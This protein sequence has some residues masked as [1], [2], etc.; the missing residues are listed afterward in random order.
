MATDRMQRQI[1]RVTGTR[2]PQGGAML[3]GMDAVTPKG[4]APGWARVSAAAAILALAGCAQPGVPGG[5][6][7][8]PASSAAMPQMPVIRWP[9]GGANAPAAGG[10]SGAVTGTPQVT[11]PFAGQ[12]VAQPEIPP[13]GKVKKTAAPATDSGAGTSAPPARS[14]GTTSSAQT[15]TVVAGETGWSVARKY[16]VSI[17]DLARAN[18]LPETMAIRVGQKLTIPAG[19]SVTAPSVTAPG[20]GSPTPEP[21]SASKPL[22]DEKTQPAS[23]P[24]PKA[25]APDLGKTRTTASGSGKLAMPVSGSIVRAYKKGTNEGIDISAP[26]GSAVSA[27]ASGTVAAVTRD[28]DGVPIVVVRHDD[29]LMTVYAGIDKLSVAKGDS[30]KRGQGIGAA[31]NDGV[32]HFEVRKGFDSVDP[33]DYL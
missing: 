6:G 1:R 12:G 23:K 8:G 31:R 9:L 20:V 5:A 2:L 32:V 17:Q 21:P 3:D 16:G 28:T 22:P 25:D 33:E 15:H 11:D 10:A 27:A 18:G 19:A 14:G 7:A 30:V 13:T 4:A 24:A 29:G 26:A